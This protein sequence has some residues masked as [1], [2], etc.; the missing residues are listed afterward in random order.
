M[1]LYFL[2]TGD[3]ELRD[4]DEAYGPSDIDG[5]RRWLKLDDCHGKLASEFEWA[6]PIRREAQS[7]S[8][9]SAYA[10]FYRG[11]FVALFSAPQ[12]AE[13]WVRKDADNLYRFLRAETDPSS[14]LL[15][16]YRGGELVYKISLITLP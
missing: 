4:G 12:E 9:Q 8:P 2:L 16:Y 11:E 7:L 3:D 14:G 6:G 10:A 1:K 13:D 15:E 5:K